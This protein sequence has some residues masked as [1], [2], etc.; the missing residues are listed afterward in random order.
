MEQKCFVFHLIIIFVLFVDLRQFKEINF[1]LNYP[2]NNFLPILTLDFQL[3]ANQWIKLKR[4]NPQIIL[5]EQL[6]KLWQFVFKAD[7]DIF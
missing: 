7:L 3:T 5:N 6:K 2:L 1:Y 4:N